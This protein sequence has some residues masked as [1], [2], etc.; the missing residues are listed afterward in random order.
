MRTSLQPAAILFAAPLLAEYVADAELN[1]EKALLA[2][3][4]DERPF[5]ALFKGGQ[6]WP[7]WPVGVLL[8]PWCCSGSTPGMIGS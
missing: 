6:G 7:A 5:L 4:M 3:T 2:A 1:L 8:R